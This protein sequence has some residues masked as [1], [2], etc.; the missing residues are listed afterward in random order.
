MGP[1]LRAGMPAVSG[2]TRPA[3]CRPERAGCIVRRPRRTH[4]QIA[5]DADKVR[6]RKLLQGRA[7]LLPSHPSNSPIRSGIFVAPSFPR[8][9]SKLHQSAMSIASAFPRFF[10]KLHRSDIY[11]GCAA[12][13]QPHA[14]WIRAFTLIEMLVLIATLVVMAALVLP[15]TVRPQHQCRMWCVNNLKQVGLSFRLWSGDHN[16]H[17]PMELAGSCQPDAPA[18]AIPT[19]GITTYP[20]AWE[21]F[22]IMSKELS[23]PK[24]LTC[25]Q[26]LQR[27]PAANFINGFDSSHISFFL[28]IDANETHPDRLLC[29]DRNITNGQKNRT[30]ILEIT[31]NQPVGWVKPFHNGNGNV[32]LAD[33]SVQEYSAAALKTLLT[34][35]GLSTNRLAMP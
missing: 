14:A 2:S 32:A 11:F 31:T 33:G 26:D 35:T 1:V 6:P 9:F 23:T 5:T 12:P 18:H 15:M 4:P 16:D 19:N 10:P 29:G 28:G 27:T 30:D 20:Y 34:K 21:I 22:Q 25:P 3:L 7:R 24:I 17:F 13:P 8:R